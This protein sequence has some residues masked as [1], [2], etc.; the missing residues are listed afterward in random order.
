[1]SEQASAYD[2]NARPGARA[3]ALAIALEIS[4]FA[5]LLAD[6][7]VQQLSAR[8]GRTVRPA[9]LAPRP[10]GGLLAAACGDAD[11]ADVEFHGT[12][13]GQITNGAT[14]LEVDV[15]LERRGSKVDGS[16][17]FG[18]GFGRLEGEVA[19]ATLT[20]QWT[21]PPDSGRG[22]ITLSNGDYQGTWGIGTADLGG[23]SIHL[24][25]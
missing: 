17:S 16:Y 18:A 19:G 24:R 12:L 5:Y 22:R 14:P 10:R 6:P 2:R 15:V 8:I 21:L 11:A 7:G 3:T 20:Y 23:G 9:D 1:M 25:R 4:Q 13:H